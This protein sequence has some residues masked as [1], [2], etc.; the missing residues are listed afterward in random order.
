MVESIG[1]KLGLEGWPMN[2]PQLKSHSHTI[3]EWK[4]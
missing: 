1:V 2:L 3:E 4:T